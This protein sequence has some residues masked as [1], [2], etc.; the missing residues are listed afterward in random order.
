MSLSNTKIMDAYTLVKDTV[1]AIA[2]RM[3]VDED[4][5][6]PVLAAL[7]AALGSR[8]G[9]TVVGEWRT[10]DFRPG[11]RFYM[12][13]LHKVQP[14][15]EFQIDGYGERHRVHRTHYALQICRIPTQRE[16]TLRNVLHLAFYM[17][18]FL[19]KLRVAHLP[20]GVV[21]MFRDMHMDKL[22]YYITDVQG[23]MATSSSYAPL[24]RQAID[25]MKAAAI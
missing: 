20:S 25:D 5:F 6:D 23:F 13:F 17:A 9:E 18:L 19:S 8:A 3:D 7:D 15:Y 10:E 4:D 24:I 16:C 12:Q 11:G 2:A 14:L 1:D 22:V 21:T